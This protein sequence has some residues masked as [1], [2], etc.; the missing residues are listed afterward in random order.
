L[1]KQNYSFLFFLQRIAIL[2]CNQQRQDDFIVIIKTIGDKFFLFLIPIHVKQGDKAFK[3][4][5]QLNRTA[6]SLI[7]LMSWHNQGG[8]DVGHPATTITTWPK[9]CPFPIP[10]I[11]VLVM[12]MKRFAK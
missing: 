5:R 2:C 11:W 7:I 4:L 12:L 9:K 3:E 6:K 1:I 8:G 10:V